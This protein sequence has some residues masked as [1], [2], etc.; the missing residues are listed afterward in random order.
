MLRTQ[1]NMPMSARF[2][3]LFL[4]KKVNTPENLDKFS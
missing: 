2:F 3:L 1:H 4:K